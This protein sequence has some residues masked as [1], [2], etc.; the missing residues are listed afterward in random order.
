[1]DLGF[2]KNACSNKGRFVKEWNSI[3]L[4]Y[5]GRVP[6]KEKEGRGLLGLFFGFITYQ[7]CEVTN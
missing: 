5:K 2:L 7:T 1:V 3:L 6:Q 4:C